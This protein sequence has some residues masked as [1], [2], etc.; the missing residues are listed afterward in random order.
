MAGRARRVSRAR[1]GS[2]ALPLIC[3]LAL[4]ALLVP[5]CGNEPKKKADPEVSATPTSASPSPSVPVADP[6]HAVDPPGPFMGALVRAD[7]L[8]YAPSPSPST[9][10]TGST[11]SRGLPTPSSSPWLRSP[12]RTGC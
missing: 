8:I 12:S 7:I 3:L 9:W 4:S 1:S 2:A 11:G 5:A 10:C 6:E